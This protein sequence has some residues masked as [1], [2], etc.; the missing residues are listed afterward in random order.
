MNGIKRNYTAPWETA[1][2]WLSN[3]GSNSAL[4]PRFLDMGRMV[5]QDMV[6]L[7]SRSFP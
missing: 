1:H 7:L 2:E 3:N 6:V 4:G 5:E